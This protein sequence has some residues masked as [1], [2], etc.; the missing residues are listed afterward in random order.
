MAAQ[1]PTRT[2]DGPGKGTRSSEPPDLPSGKLAQLR[3]AYKVTVE[4]DK[5]LPL[6]LLGAFAIDFAVIL[7]LGLL[8]GHVVFGSVFAVLT[9]LLAAMFA[10]G[11]R[12]QKSAYAR[13]EGQMGAAASVLQQ[14][15]RGGWTVTPG[16]AVSRQQDVL[17]RAVG[18]PGIVLIGEGTARGVAALLDSERKRMNRFVQDAPVVE[19]VVG[20]AE[21]QVPLRKLT[22]HMMKLERKLRPGQ[23]TEINDRLRAV[24]D[25]MSN[26]PMPKG[27]MPKG[28]RMP[29]GPKPR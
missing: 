2:N 1:R 3:M 17:H 16:V 10:F 9:G 6:V 4:H 23:L 18:R 20:D 12:V 27:P 22:K 11:T 19:V 7:G 24:G 8:I 15:K 14:M 13:I 28:A 5:K 21:G 29:K 25:L 26:L